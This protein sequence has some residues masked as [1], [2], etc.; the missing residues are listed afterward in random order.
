[1]SGSCPSPVGVLALWVFLAPFVRALSQ[2]CVAHRQ[3]P[4]FQDPLTF[5]EVAVYFT[6]QEWQWLG[7]HQRQF[8]WAVTLE[9]YGNM[10]SLGEDYRQ[11]SLPEVLRLKV[12]G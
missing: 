1:M 12:V 10:A 2:P 11:P 9:N 3:L 5:K 6:N 7:P 8:S 4:M